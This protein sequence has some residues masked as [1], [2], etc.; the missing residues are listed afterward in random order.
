MCLLTVIVMRLIIVL[1]EAGLLTEALPPILL[2]KTNAGPSPKVVEMISQ[3]VNRV[4]IEPGSM[5]ASEERKHKGCR[6]DAESVMCI[7]TIWIHTEGERGETQID[8]GGAKGQR[9]HV[10]S[11]ILY[12]PAHCYVIILTHRLFGLLK[13]QI[14]VKQLFNP[15]F[16]NFTVFL[17]ELRRLW[18][19]FC[20]E[21]WNVYQH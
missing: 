2:F 8:M 1:A 20:K 14:H 7:N 15:F 10:H 3:H 16:S 11:S 13:K 17:P 19:F 12:L 21:F 9:S 18:H 4:W 5:E 6:K